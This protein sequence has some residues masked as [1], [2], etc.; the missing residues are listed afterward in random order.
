MNL[1]ESLAS[2]KARLNSMNKGASFLVQP[3]NLVY[4]KRA[5]D[6]VDGNHHRVLG[7]LQ[8]ILDK[9]E[10]AEA[11]KIRGLSLEMAA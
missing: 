3:H 2:K 8:Q 1:A 7:D 4:N 10:A 9:H 11:K 6:A 5:L